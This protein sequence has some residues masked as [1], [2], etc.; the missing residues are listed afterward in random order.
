MRVGRVWGVVLGGITTV[1]GHLWSEL[2]SAAMG[3]Y[4]VTI[5]AGIFAVAA[6][7]EIARP[8]TARALPL[9]GR[10]VE[11]ERP[12]TLSVRRRS[13]PSAGSVRVAR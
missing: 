5:I 13:D 3:T 4:Y 8:R 11:L 7:W 2:V 9:E 1:I 10:M 6:I 12:V